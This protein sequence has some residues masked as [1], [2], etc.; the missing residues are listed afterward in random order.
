MLI[1]CCGEQERKGN[2][3]VRKSLQSIVNNQLTMFFVNDIIDNI[4]YIIRGDL[5]YE[6]DYFSFFGNCGFIFIW[7]H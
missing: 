6:K 4:N 1:K 7:W 2:G 5:Q 3:R